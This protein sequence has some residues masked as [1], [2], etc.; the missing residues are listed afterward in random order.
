MSSGSRISCALLFCLTCLTSRSQSKEPKILDLR[1]ILGASRV[2]VVPQS[3]RFI[4]EEELIVLAGPTSEC[5]DAVNQI[6][7]VAISL[8]GHIVAR[9]SWTSTD[10]GVV[11]TPERLVLPRSDGVDVLD[12]ALQTIQTLRISR[13]GG[14]VSIQAT[15]TGILSVVTKEGTHS[16]AGTPLRPVDL[17][18][19]RLIRGGDEVVSTLDGS[20][21]LARVNN[22]LVQQ[23]AGAPS[24]VFVD[25]GWVAPSC[26]QRDFCQT[27][28]SS[29]H[30]QTVMG[31]R[32]RILITASG[33]KVP[34]F[35][36]FGLMPFF[37]MQV[38]D[39]ETGAEVYREEDLF[40][41]RQRSAVLSPDGDLVV[42]SDGETA[43]TH[44]LL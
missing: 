15:D 24:R 7:I 27:D 32:S 23:R 6:E 36:S 35:S 12:K 3:V 39:L 22:T 29:I 33:T 37:R 2:C 4:S 5:Y 38:L 8:D 20:W 16:Y 34:V 11:L 43:T 31:K 42:V 17:R 44:E 30:F 40:R 25:L 41:A 13:H 9:R 18:P 19:S 21:E 26:E 14:I 1:A 10:P 28:Q